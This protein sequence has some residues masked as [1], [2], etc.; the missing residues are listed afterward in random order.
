MKALR[1]A[2]WLE[3]FVELKGDVWLEGFVVLNALSFDVAA[4]MVC[5]L[6]AGWQLAARG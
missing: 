3:C 1:G 4:W 2:V 6:D 5:A